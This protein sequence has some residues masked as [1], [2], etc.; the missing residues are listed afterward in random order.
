VDHTHHFLFY[1]LQHLQFFPC[2]LLFQG[3]G[4]FFP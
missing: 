4:E 2:F 3:V 1:S